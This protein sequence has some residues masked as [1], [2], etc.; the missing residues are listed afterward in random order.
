[1]YLNNMRC[2]EKTGLTVVRHYINTNANDL[3]DV[4][5]KD[6]IIKI[7]KYV[8]VLNDT[9]IQTLTIHCTNEQY[10]KIRDMLVHY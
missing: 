1:M 7:Y 5:F 2:D 3:I 8:S 10:N 9:F 6:N 4:I